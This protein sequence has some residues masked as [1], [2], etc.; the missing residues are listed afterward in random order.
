MLAAAWGTVWLVVEWTAPPAV[1]H[2]LAAEVLP[3]IDEEVE[4]GP[5]LLWRAR[6]ELQPR[7]FCVERV[8]EVHARAWWAEHGFSAAGFARL[9]RLPA[10][11]TTAPQAREAFGLPPD[12]PV[13][14]T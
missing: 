6:P 12:A 5:G 9:D 1:D 4:R 8:I 10:E 3:V 13:R 2:V 7:W 14:H 11:E